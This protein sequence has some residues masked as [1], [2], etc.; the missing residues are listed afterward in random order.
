MV[1]VRACS[2]WRR[3]CAGKMLNIA[4]GQKLL[5]TGRFYAAVD[6]VVASGGGLRQ[7]P[8]WRAVPCNAGAG[9][10][11]G[12]RRV[13]L[14]EGLVQSPLIVRAFRGGGTFGS[15]THP[16]GAVWDCF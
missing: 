4:S 5:E 1:V 16:P 3:I 7:A 6:R 11:D 10:V 14:H 2:A 8:A 15:I 13:R 12:P 9:R